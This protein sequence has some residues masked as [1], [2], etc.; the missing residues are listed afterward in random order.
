[1]ESAVHTDVQSP[2]LLDQVRSALRV[3]H[4]SYETEKSYIKWIYRYI[5]FHNKK[6]P[7]ELDESDISQFISY[8][9]TTQKVS[10]STQNQALCA[11]VFLYKEVLKKDPGNFDLVWAKKSRR[12]PVVFSKQEIADI[13]KQLSGVHW[14]LAMLMYGSG[15]RRMECL[16]LRVK[17]ID[18]AYNQITVRSGK[19]DR[20][21]VVPL[22]Q[23]VKN[24]LANHLKKVGIQHEKDLK[25]GYG[26]VE[27]PDALEKKYRNADKNRE[28]QYVFPAH[29]ISKDPRT[30]IE[31]RHHLYESVIQKSVKSAIRKAGIHKHGSCHSLRHSFATHL[32]EDG[33]DIRTVQELLGHKHLE[34][35]MI[36]THVMNKGGLAVRSP[37]DN[38]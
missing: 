34:T 36:Y 20:D 24:P 35:T 17:D 15:M 23:A 14:I 11:I 2:K 7:Q 21:R 16:R 12:I 3:K 4:Y 18:F 32:L 37:A 30:G 13:L 8:L 10:A 38:L 5:C 29:R 9:A 31:R 25:A 28:W 19:G 22:P 6:H 26:S 27:L 1:M 33:Y